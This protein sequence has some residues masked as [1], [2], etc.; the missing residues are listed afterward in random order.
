MYWRRMKKRIWKKG[1]R[2]EKEEGWDQG[3]AD[4]TKRNVCDQKEAGKT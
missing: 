2:E 4:L 1:N 3:C